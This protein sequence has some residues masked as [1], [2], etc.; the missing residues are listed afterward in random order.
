MFQLDVQQV[1]D[2]AEDMNR[3]FERG[4]EILDTCLTI[5][6]RLLSFTF[7]KILLE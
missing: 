4:K 3:E 1:T 2:T 7:A 6:M 5:V